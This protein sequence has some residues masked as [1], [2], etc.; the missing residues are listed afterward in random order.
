MEKSNLILE[1]ETDLRSKINEMKNKKIHNPSLFLNMANEEGWYEAT[2]KLIS[3][4]KNTTGFTDLLLKGRTDLSLES[5]VVQKKYNS[6]FS[7]EEIK[8]CQSRLS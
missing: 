2:K 8:M 4:P 3:K 7:N 6:L 1:F 5:L